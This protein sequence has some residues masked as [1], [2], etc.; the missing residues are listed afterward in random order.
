MGA[1]PAVAESITYTDPTAGPQ[2]F[3]V[4]AGVC[5][6]TVDALGAQGGSGGAF[7]AHAPGARVVANLPVTPGESLQVN[8]GGEGGDGE[9]ILADAADAALGNTVEQSVSAAAIAAGGAGGINGGGA[10][11]DSSLIGGGGGGGASDVRQAPGGSGCVPCPA[12]G[13][14]SD[15]TSLGDRVIVAGGGGGAGAFTGDGGGLGG[16]GGGTSGGDPD[17]DGGH[18][19]PQEPPEQA[20]TGGTVGTASAGGVGGIGSIGYNESQAGDGGDGTAGTGG[21]GGG[22]LDANGGGGGGGGGYFGGGGGGGVTPGQGSAGGGGGGSSF[23]AATAT[24]VTFTPGVATGDGSVTLSWEV[25]SDSAPGVGCS[26][27][28]A[29][30]VVTPKFTG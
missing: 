13:T 14:A 29:A 28:P 17:G 16:V 7:D 8:V 10:G 5:S 4:P 23:A 15:G 22:L 18:G 24:N 6:V 12:P 2:T 21:V 1:L 19:T 27:A 11:G 30:L 26:A 9:E 3:V 25:S 20:A